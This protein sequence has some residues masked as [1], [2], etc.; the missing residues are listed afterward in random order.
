MSNPDRPGDN[1]TMR[2]RWLFVVMVFCMAII[3]YCVG[4]ADDSE[5]AETAVSMG[6]L[7][8]GASISTYVFGSAW[9]FISK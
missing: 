7:T 4:W 8:L 2:R 9:E 6:F 3:T 1:W 5:V